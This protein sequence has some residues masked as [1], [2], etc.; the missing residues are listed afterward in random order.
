MAA[1]VT[2]VYG[3]FVAAAS[4]TWLAV[5]CSHCRAVWRELLWCF[6]GLMTAQLASHLTV[7]HSLRGGWL[8]EMLVGAAISAMLVALATWIARQR[9]LLA[10]PAL[11]ALLALYAYLALAAYACVRA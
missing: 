10:W 11:M 3:P 4:Y 7:R 1:G 6:P 9:R 5:D 2:V 8:I